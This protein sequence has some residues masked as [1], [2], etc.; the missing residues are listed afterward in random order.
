MTS[1]CIAI[2]MTSTSTFK[3]LQGLTC[4]T[5]ELRVV[6]VHRSRVIIENHPFNKRVVDTVLVRRVDSVYILK[7]IA[8]S[9]T[10]AW[11]R[12]P[13]ERHVPQAQPLGNRACRD[14]N[15]TQSGRIACWNGI[16]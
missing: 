15:Q 4:S 3:L 16:D 5:I 1:H 13:P 2:Q 14:H 6:R 11:L 10:F 7:R 8:T 9:S 12:V